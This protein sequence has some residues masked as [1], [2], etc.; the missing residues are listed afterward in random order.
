[1]RF[2]TCHRKPWGR[3]FGDIN[4]EAAD[5]INHNHYV[6]HLFTSSMPE[7]V[8]RFMDKP[9]KATGTWTGSIMGIMAADHFKFKAMVFS[10]MDD[11][12]V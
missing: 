4:C 7:Q 8:A 9:C 5:R 12:E 10:R 1:M 2:W 3:R 11:P 6:D